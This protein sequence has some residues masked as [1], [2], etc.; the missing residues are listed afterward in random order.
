[1]KGKMMKIKRMMK[2]KGETYGDGGGDGG[3]DDDDCG[4]HVVCDNDVEGDDAR[5]ST[6]FFLCDGLN[7]GA[8]DAIED[9]R[10]VY[11]GY[12]ELES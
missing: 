1:M 11:E 9:G 6:I 12:E 7:S 2:T 3:G 8:L 4:K 10:T 5:A